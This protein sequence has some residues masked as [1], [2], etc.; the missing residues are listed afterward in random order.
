MKRERLAVLGLLLLVGLMLA[1]G[2]SGLVINQAELDADATA[3][4]YAIC[5]QVCQRD[6]FA[7]D[8]RALCGGGR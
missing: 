1:C 4:T 8:C 7:G 2:G 3:T 6:Q 5:V